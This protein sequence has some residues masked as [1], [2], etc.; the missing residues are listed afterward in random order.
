M[1]AISAVLWFSLFSSLSTQEVLADHPSPDGGG[2]E[3]SQ[4]E[5]ESVR[6]DFIE[7][8]E[9]ETPKVA[10]NR[11]REE[12]K[13]D[14]ALA[15]V[16]HWLVHKIGHAAYEKYQD[17]GEAMKFQDEVCNSGYLHGIIESHFSEQTDVMTAIQ[18]V[19]EVYAA[20]SYIEWQCQHGVGHGLMYYT[21][22][23]LLGS[24]AICDSSATERARENCVNGAFMENFN[25]DSVIHPSEFLSEE[26][27][28]YPCPE[29]A[30]RHKKHC[31]AYAPT[32]YL[33]KNPTDY[34]GA[35]K[36][37]KKAE[38]G[39]RSTCVYGVGAQAMKENINDQELVES[40]CMQGA[41]KQTVPC[42]KG[43]VQQYIFHFGALEP[44]EKLCPTL[45]ESNTNSCIRTVKRN[46]HY[47]E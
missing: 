28:F 10:L 22:N 18:T 15:R 16:C 37:C 35:L 46:A 8:V 21:A 6:R 45:K 44:A 20:G 23:D 43:M 5:Y 30:R 25:S 13:T 24:L 40:L 39:F 12:I 27:L 31:Y 32:H 14:D 34:S 38:S 17:F 9:K 29:M 4:A 7:I 41:R 36:W 1:V 33:S 3:L 26:D 11:L 42:V 19:C 47:F 2:A